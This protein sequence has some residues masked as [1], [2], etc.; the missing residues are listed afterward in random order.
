MALHSSL[1]FIILL[2]FTKCLALKLD[3]HGK[4]YE[5]IKHVTDEV[6]IDDANFPP[7]AEV[8]STTPPHCLPFQPL[9]LPLAKNVE[10]GN[11]HYA[12][13]WKCGDNISVSFNPFHPKARLTS[14][15]FA[16]MKSK[17]F[18]FSFRNALY[19]VKNLHS[20]INVNIDVHDPF[21]MCVNQDSSYCDG[22]ATIPLYAEYGNPPKSKHF[23]EIVIQQ[24]KDGQRFFRL[25]P[26]ILSAEDVMLGLFNS[27]TLDN[28]EKALD[29]SISL[30]SV[31]HD[32]DYY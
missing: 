8:I 18:Q 20:S 1:I 3:E 30:H 4:P 25:Y 5:D 24:R 13:L 11:M 26:N 32:E 16:I 15:D 22:F 14:D 7:T 27:T 10:T 31:L 28:V 23:H 6:I 12:L 19:A 29:H 17:D 9:V 21:L 2:A